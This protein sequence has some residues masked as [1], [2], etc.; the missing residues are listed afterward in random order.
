MPSVSLR[1]VLRWYMAQTSLRHAL[2]DQEVQTNRVSTGRCPAPKGCACQGEECSDC[3]AM[4]CRARR[5]TFL[6]VY[7]KMLITDSLLLKMAHVGLL[8]SSGTQGARGEHGSD[9]HPHFLT[10]SQTHTNSQAL[11]QHPGHCGRDLFWLII[12]L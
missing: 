3:T 6:P 9:T 11:T 1:Q 10:H 4:M 2:L 12:S 7:S 8:Q 5:L